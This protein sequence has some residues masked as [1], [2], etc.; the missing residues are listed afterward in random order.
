M[1]HGMYTTIH[2][3]F[4]GLHVSV[5]ET[6]TELLE[7]LVDNYNDVEWVPPSQFTWQRA[8]IGMI[9]KGQSLIPKEKTVVQE[10][11]ID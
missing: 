9:F 5:Y 11:D 1:S 8:N 6:K 10:W 7:A 3:S 4:D 2:T